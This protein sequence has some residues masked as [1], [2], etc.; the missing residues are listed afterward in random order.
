MKP[1]VT[2]LRAD[3]N[4]GVTPTDED[5]L[6]IIA[7]SEKGTVN[8]PGTFTRRQDVLAEYGSGPLLEDCASAIAWTRKPV[9]AVRAAASTSGA[10]GTVTNTGAGTAALTAGTSD[11][12]DAFDV[13]VDFPVGGTVGVAGITYRTSLDGGITMSAQLALGTATEIVIPDTGITLELG[14]GTIVAGTKATFTTTAPSSS[15]A[16]LLAAL[17]GLRVSSAPWEGVLVRGDATS[18]MVSTLDQWL[19]DLETRGIY[20]FAFACFRPR[21]AAETEADY[22]ADV[23]ILRAA[24]SSIRV[25]VCADGGDVASLVRGVKQYRAA[26][27]G[28]VARTLSVPIGTDPAYVQLGPL[29]GYEIADA[30]G[31]PKHHDE[32]LFPMLDDLGVCSLRSMPDRAGVYPTNVRAFS[33]VGSD[34]VFAQHVR[35]MNRALRTANFILRGELSRGVAKNPKPGPGGA[36]YI[37]ETAAQELELLVNT[38]VGKVLE[39]QVSD[40]LF[41]LSRTDDI[42][43]NE[44]AVLTGELAIEALAYV[45]KFSFL[46]KF[47]R[48]ITARAA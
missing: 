18:T 23:A 37:D 33:P 25:F 11:P 3:G 41:T 26:A 2:A 15:N 24:A 46:A 34:Y 44:G 39:G 48:T 28:I 45:K 8:L 35:C 31:M 9:V 36:V 22:A 4:T 13:L 16:D 30:R 17:E 38:A 5:V 19:A 40:Y 7:P 42:G 6:A 20:K 43:S 47:V 21:A 14:T 12:L 32:E 1:T 29:P 27:T 10:Y